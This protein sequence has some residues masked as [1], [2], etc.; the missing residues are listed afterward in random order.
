MFTTIRTPLRSIAL[1][2]SMLLVTAGILIAPTF[3]SN[4]RADTTDTT[5]GQTETIPDLGAELDSVPQPS[6]LSAARSTVTRNQIVLRWAAPPANADV[7]GYVATLYSSVDGTVPLQA[8]YVTPQ[9]QFPGGWSNSWNR[10]ARFNMTG[11]SVGVFW[12]TV[13]AVNSNHNISRQASPRVPM[14]FSSFGTPLAPIMVT[15]TPYPA[16]HAVGLTW[17]TVLGDEGILSLQSW[18][19]EYAPVGTTNPMWFSFADPSARAVNLFN[20]APGDYWVRIAGK[21]SRGV[22]QYSIPVQVTL[23]APSTGG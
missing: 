14:P 4:A 19:V 23:T 10:I 11:L 18:R 16:S 15:A 6:G 1:I 2:L 20:M 12:L 17:R 22:G 7:V 5:S 8:W 3:T 13:R 9:A 21:N